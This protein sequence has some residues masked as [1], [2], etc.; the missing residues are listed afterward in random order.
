MKLWHS[1]ISSWSLG[2]WVRYLLSWMTHHGECLLPYVEDVQAAL[3]T[4][5]R[6]ELLACSHVWKLS[7]EH[8]S[9]FSQ[10]FRWGHP[11]WHLDCNLMG[12]CVKKNSHGRADTAILRKL[13]LQDWLL[14]GTWELGF[15]EGFCRSLGLP[16]WLSSK[17]SA[18]SGGDMGSILGLGRSAGEGN[19]N[20]LQYS[21][22]NDPKN[23][24]AWWA[25]EHG[26]ARVSHDLAT[27]TPPLRATIF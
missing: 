13:C 10:Y 22:Q 8:T 18:C 2:L 12:Y 14:A 20:P 26:V 19:G 9:S 15:R 4:P 7:Y 23:K 16:C 3:W 24:G 27:T 17:E 5:Q 6:R 21:W 11:N 1:E 25:P